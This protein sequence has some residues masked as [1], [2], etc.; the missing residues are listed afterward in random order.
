MWREPASE[1]TCGPLTLPTPDHPRPR[2]P[3]APEAYQPV[4]ASTTALAVSGKEDLTVVCV[5][6]TSALK[7]H[8]GV[9]SLKSL[10]LGKAP[11][12]SGWGSGAAQAAWGAGAS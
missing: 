5:C 1:G 4:P 10:G 2:R 8:R 7:V 12:S 3:Q 9:L 11:L 6:R